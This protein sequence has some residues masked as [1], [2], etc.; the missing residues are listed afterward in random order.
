MKRTGLIIILSGAAM[1]GCTNL[2]AQM[3]VNEGQFQA[4]NFAAQVEDPTAAEGAPVMSAAMSD[5]AIARYEAGEVGGEDE[6]DAAV[7]TFNMTPAE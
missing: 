1:M 3:S 4:Q 7:F 2:S 5:A 6:G